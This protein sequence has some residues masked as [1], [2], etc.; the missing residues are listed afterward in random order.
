MRRRRARNIRS[1]ITNR[2]ARALEHARADAGAYW[3]PLSGVERR[4]SKSRIAAGRVASRILNGRGD[5]DTRREPEAGT[6]CTGL[7]R[8]TNNRA[9][10]ANISGE[11]LQLSRARCFSS[12]SFY[13]FLLFFLPFSSSSSSFQSRF[14]L[15][16]R[17]FSTALP[18]SGGEEL[19]FKIRHRGEFYCSRGIAR[20]DLTLAPLAPLCRRDAFFARARNANWP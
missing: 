18:T 15:A 12:P 14:T 5:R 11:I 9:S 10:H 16:P 1:T 13:L 20:I 17:G 4:E 3:L 6:I 7:S 2:R 19:N 8:Y